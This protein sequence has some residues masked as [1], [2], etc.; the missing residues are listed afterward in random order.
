MNFLIG[1]FC[2]NFVNKI[3]AYFQIIMEFVNKAN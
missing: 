1:K 2:Y 3:E